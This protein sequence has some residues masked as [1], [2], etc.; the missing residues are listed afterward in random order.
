[1]AVELALALVVGPELLWSDSRLSESLES[2]QSELREQ[3]VETEQ[4][5]CNYCCLRNGR[6]G[7]EL[8][9]LEDDE[10]LREAKGS[11]LE[12]THD[13]CLAWWWLAAETSTTRKGAC[14]QFISVDAAPYFSSTQ[15][16]LFTQMAE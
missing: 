15:S 1:M 3:M 4:V 6:K 14:A 7:N 13:T 16:E 2:A 12:D 8:R 10:G 5:R 11:L 9:I